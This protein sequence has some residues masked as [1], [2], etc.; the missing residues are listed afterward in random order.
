M[1][2][3][4]LNETLTEA[5]QVNPNINIEWDSNNFCTVHA[6][7]KD[8]KADQFRI[9]PLIPT[10]MPEFDPNTSTVTRN[11]HEKIGDKWYY[12]WK[13]NFFTPDQ[14][15]ERTATHRAN[16]IKQIDLDTDALYEA[17]LGNR[18]QE[19]VLAEAEANSYKQA[20]YSGAIPPSVA[21]WAN[22]KSW[23]SVQAA[24][25]IL[26]TAIGQRTAQANIRAM[27][28]SCKEAARTATDL[29]AVSNQWNSFL[30][31][32]SKALGVS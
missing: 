15:I 13:I 1:E 20:G 28:L 10:P 3:L 9:I 30:I 17:V 25:N 12:K 2:Y 21:S 23:T 5:I 29:T 26:S 4:Q 27:R 31:T 18:A 14:L 7:I 16:L 19:Y 32:I 22:A 8:G 11:G 6:L 24:N